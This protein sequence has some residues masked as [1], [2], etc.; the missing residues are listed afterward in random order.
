M[1]NK[2]LNKFD[3]IVKVEVTGRNID[4]YIKKLI[5]SKVDI[6][7]LTKKNYKKIYIYVKYE[8]YIKL[9]KNKT[10]YEVKIVEQLGGLKIK[11]F[12]KKNIIM[13]ISLI[14]SILL[15]IFLSNIVFTIEV[16]HSDSNLK[17]F[18]YKELEKNGIKKYTMKKSY[19][20][21]EEIEDKILEEN[22]NK[23]EWI[24]II[25]SGTKYIVRLEERLINNDKKEN[26]YQN[27]I[28]NKSAII[29]QIIA[30]NGEKIKAINDYVTKGDII[31]SGNMLKPNNNS[32]LVHADGI[33][34]G[35]VWYTVDVEYPYIY[36]EETLTG[37][38]KKVIVLNFLN[39]RISLFD[40]NKFN[41]FQINK[42]TLLYNN[43]LP[44]NLVLE[45]QYEV[46]IIDDFLTHDEAVNRAIELGKTKLLESNNKIKEIKKVS[47]LKENKLAS[48]V[49]LKLFISVIEDIG[50]AQ[51]IEDY[52][53]E[54]N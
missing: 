19:N 26:N 25:E 37:K 16:I 7:K 28:A 17:K 33:V 53:N 4:N 35:E 23:L 52:I 48:K 31:I 27:I 12:I 49:S 29:T 36:K 44:I 3:D 51:N 11:E 6:I 8:D 24:E 38:N 39:K 15:L 46:N 20:Y 14:L 1:E 18:V 34:Y 22:K 41:S 54:N 21:L 13:F 43:I 50:I 45:K 32:V 9:K 30:Y 2:F 47:I 10:I 42:K 5:K 40:F